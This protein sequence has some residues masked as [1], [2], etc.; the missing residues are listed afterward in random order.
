MFDNRDLQILEILQ[1]DGRSTASDIAK[2]VD[3]SIPTVGERIKK[4]I[5]KGIINKFVAVL[6]HKNAGLD[7]TAFIFIVS[8]HSDHYDEFI[9]KTN[10]CKAVMECHSITGGGSHILKIRAKNSQGL[11]DLLYEIQ[12]WPGVSRTKSNVVL[13]SYKETTD[14]NLQSFIEQHNIF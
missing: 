3:L 5:K 4:L 12:N 1:K 8:E 10:E 6:N 14:I 2:E 11:E 7:L 9:K 13:S